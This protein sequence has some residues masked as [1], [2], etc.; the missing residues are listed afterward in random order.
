MYDTEPHAIISPT[1]SICT[2]RVTAE[3]NDWSATG[4]YD[5]AFGKLTRRSTKGQRMVQKTYPQTMTYS[6]AMYISG[7]DANHVEELV[8]FIPNQD[9]TILRIDNFSKANAFEL[10]SPA[11]VRMIS[12]L[13]SNPMRPT[14]SPLVRFLALN[15]GCSYLISIGR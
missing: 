15:A 14:V 10:S 12:G 2:I 7:G 1:S 8:T 4:G 3:N 13:F 9:F 11:L 6:F 5:L